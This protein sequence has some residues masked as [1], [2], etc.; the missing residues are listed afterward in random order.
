MQLQA[1]GVRNWRQVV[2]RA[3]RWLPLALLIVV[4]AVPVG[5]FGWFFFYTDMFTVQAVTVVDAHD[6]TEAAVR[7]IIEKRVA[8]APQHNIFF[9]QP[10]L[11]EVD[12]M[13]LPQVRTVYVQRKLPGTIKVIVQEKSPALLLLSNTHYYFVDEAGVAFEE[14]S[15]ARLPGV[16]L[17]TVKNDDTRAEV[18]LGAEVVAPSF[19]LFLQTIQSELPRRINREVAQIRIPSLSAREV[20]VTLDSNWQIRFDVTRPAERQL[21]ILEQTLATIGAEAQAQ[22]Q[23]IDL[24]IDRRVYWA[25]REPAGNASP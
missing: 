3:A 2:S 4:M 9:V 19:V 25:L 24:R 20:H 23:Y 13:A 10:E 1:V 7:A 6:H 5:L 15:L 12:I 22:L 18:T 14:A 16:V 11:M 21:D 8:Q 17:P